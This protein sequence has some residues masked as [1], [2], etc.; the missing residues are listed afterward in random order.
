MLRDL[1]NAAVLLTQLLVD[2]MGG[3]H[4]T[5]AHFRFPSNKSNVEMGTE[6]KR[7]SE[8]RGLPFTRE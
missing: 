4:F 8:R 5:A 7:E 6:E 1:V 2:I 3:K